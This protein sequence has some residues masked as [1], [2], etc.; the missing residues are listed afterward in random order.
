MRRSSHPIA[1]VFLLA[2]T[3]S[4]NAFLLPPSFQEKSLARSSTRLQQSSR[5]SAEDIYAAVHRK[6]YEMKQVR[7]Q[8][9]S[10]TDPVRMAMS[11][12]QES[13]SPM[14]LARALRRVYEDPLN[15]ANPDSQEQ[16]EEHMQGGGMSGM[17]RA[18]F[19]VDIK[20]KSLSRPGEVFCNYDDAGMVAQAMVRLGADA[21]FVNTD[22]SAYGGDMTEL[23]SAVKAVRQVSST[24]AVVMKDIVVDEI[25]LGLAKHAGADGIVL[26]SCVLGEALDSFLDLATV[27]GLECIVECHTRN[28]VERALNVNVA[29][30]ILVTNYDRVSQQ[31]FPDQAVQLAGLFPGSGGPIITLATGGIATT[32]DMKRHL[33]VGYDG[34]VVG[35]AVMGSPKAPEFIRAVRDRTLLPAELSQW[36]QGMEFDS[37]GNIMSGPKANIP[38]PTDPSAY[39]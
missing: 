33:A 15:P 23:A 16:E 8:H 31:Y 38:S 13:V 28:E 24:A 26:Q 34:V 19:I 39:Q 9:K 11:Y 35:A 1:Y 17:R 5:R 2:A 3:S 14:R 7:A 37:D 6:E 20:R 4:S 18:S 29:P 12:A 30:T 25:Q 36:S 32:D 21:V 22:Y 27:M 10:T